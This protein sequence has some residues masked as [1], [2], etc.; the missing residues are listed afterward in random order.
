[1]GELV[2]VHNYYPEPLLVAGVSGRVL[3][4]YSISPS[5]VAQHIKVLRSDKPGFGSAAVQFLEDWHFDVPATWSRQGGP[6]HRQRLQVIF[7]IDGMAPPQPWHSDVMTFP[8]YGKV[9]ET[10]GRSR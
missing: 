1:M 6:A 7:I 9:S 4:A 3:L 8:I 10:E 5:G 2:A